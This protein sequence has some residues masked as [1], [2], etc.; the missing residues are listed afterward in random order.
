LAPGA[1]V[2]SWGGEKVGMAAVRAGQEVVMAVEKPTYF[3]HHQGEDQ[4]IPIRGMNT[5][6]DV[7]AYEPVPKELGADGA[8]HVLGA[9]GQLWTEYMPDPQRMEYMAWPR[10]SALS[11]VLL[12][13]RESRD[14][15]NFPLWLE[16]P[17]G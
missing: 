10:L 1:T 7:Y 14:A 6:A 13:P 9:Q 2:M 12:S 15:A 3:D 5:L 16:T 17:P 4:I 11:E 8:T